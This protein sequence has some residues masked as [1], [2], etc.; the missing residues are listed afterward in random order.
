VFHCRSYTFSKKEFDM[1]LFLPILLLGLVQPADLSS[2]NSSAAITSN[3]LLQVQAASQ[4]ASQS[5]QFTAAPRPLELSGDDDANSR[6]T[7]PIDRIVADHDSG[8]GPSVCLTMRSYY[9]QRRDGLAPEFVRMTSCDQLKKRALK[10]INRP[11]R[12][13]PA[14]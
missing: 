11:A 6:T 7:R 12:L 8:E 5:A 14:N 10:N 3:E 4:S 9:F 2:A 13:V 1:G